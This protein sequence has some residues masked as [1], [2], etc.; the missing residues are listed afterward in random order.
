[1]GNA[2]YSPLRG[3]Q[4]LVDTVLERAESELSNAASTSAWMPRSGERLDWQ[5]AG[6]HEW[7]RLESAEL[8]TVQ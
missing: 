3:S 5:A 2:D 4:M 7:A 6:V 1:M 8:V